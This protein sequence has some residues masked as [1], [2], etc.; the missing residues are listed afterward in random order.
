M[1]LGSAEPYLC[2]PVVPIDKCVTYSG[3]SITTICTACQTGFFVSGNACVA[4]KNGTTANCNTYFANDDSCS[5]CQ[6]NYQLITNS[7][8]NSCIAQGS[9]CKTLEATAGSYCKT[10][11]DGYMPSSGSLSCI[12]GTI[13]NCLTY[14]DANSTTYT[15]SCSV[16]A[17]GYGLANNVCTLLPKIF[18]AATTITNIKCGTAE[19]PMMV[20]QWCGLNAIPQC[21]DF[22]A[23]TTDSCAQCND[24]YQL[25]R[26]SNNTIVTPNVCSAIS[27]STNCA[28]WDETNNICQKCATGYLLYR[29]STATPP[30]YNCVAIWTY[31][32]SNC[33]TKNTIDTETTNPFIFP[34]TDA[35]NLQQLT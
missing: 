4:R 33:D 12:T 20:S 31:A 23:N 14:A 26:T 2:T 15:T 10:C 5:A 11:V 28:S 32:N 22:K 35:T 9:N 3:S 8:G 29:D 6:T 18:P 1:R 16:C 24:G 30:W 17:P 7:T 13:T 27:A 21:K 25:T 19:L 34:Q